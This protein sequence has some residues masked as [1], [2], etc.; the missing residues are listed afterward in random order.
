MGLSVCLDKSVKERLFHAILFEVVANAL[1]ILLMFLILSITP[2]ESAVLAGVSAVTATLWN[3]LYNRIFDAIQKYV[4]FSRT[5]KVRVIHAVV[6]ETGLIALLIPFA[7]WWLSLSL[8]QAFSLETGLVLFFLP[9][10]VL[11]NWAYDVLRERIVQHRRTLST[12]S[13]GNTHQ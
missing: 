2:S 13:H 6:F 4:G 1:I 9:Y 8:V 3:M 10:T 7:A 12:P 11:F 5:F